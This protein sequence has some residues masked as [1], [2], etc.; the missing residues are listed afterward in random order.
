ME[1]ASKS[2]H[3]L[4][5]MKLKKQ[6][7]PWMIVLF[8]FYWSIGFL[9]SISLD[10]AFLNGEISLPRGL[11]VGFASAMVSSVISEFIRIKMK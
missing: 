3:G 11:L 7:I 1:V 6:E 9:V 8:P 2:K 10:T 5:E 4:N